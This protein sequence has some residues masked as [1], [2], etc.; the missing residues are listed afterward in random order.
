MPREVIVG[1]GKNASDESRRDVVDVAIGA[2]E[3]NGDRA[4]PRDDA[5]VAGR[6]A[7]NA[8]LTAVARIG[9]TTSTAHATHSS[10]V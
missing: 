2:D 6:K 1:R 8:P 7:R 4:Q 5:I 9:W 10:V 3:P